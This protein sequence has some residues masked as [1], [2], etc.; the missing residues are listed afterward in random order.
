[1]KME[2]TESSGSSPIG[3]G[4]GV[5][6]GVPREVSKNLA[7]LQGFNLATK[8]GQRVLFGTF[9]APRDSEGFLSVYRAVFA[10]P[11]WSRNI[12]DPE[13][14]QQLAHLLAQRWPYF[15]V[16]VP[17]E[18]E[19]GPRK[20][21]GYCA[22]SDL[23]EEYIPIVKPHIPATDEP[24]TTR[25]FY[26]AKIGLADE[27]KGNGFANLLM[28]ERVRHAIA[29]GYSHVA[30]RTLGGNDPIERIYAKLGYVRIC[31]DP[32][33]PER[34]WW[35]L[36]LTKDPTALEKRLDAEIAMVLAARK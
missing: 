18:P 3:G 2:A 15:R 32:E 33:Y 12:S 19:T 22:G 28:A 21:L 5:S 13:A 24:V 16:V 25:V 14:R 29:S 6:V 36:D 9:D 26:E 27:V 20:V 17:H 7:R 8:A 30:S 11:P 34:N 23:P 31:A 10:P 4:F 35:L 1:M